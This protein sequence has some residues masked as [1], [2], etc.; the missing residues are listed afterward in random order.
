MRRRS[1]L[2]ALSG[3][4][5]LVAIGA[6]AG[7]G[8]QQ[9]TAAS[10]TGTLRVQLTDDPAAYDAVNLQIV[11]VAVHRGDETTAPD[12]SASDTSATGTDSSGWEVLSRDAATYDLLSLRNGVLATLAAAPIPAGHYTQVRLKLGAGSNV[13]VNGET[14]DLKVPSGMQS[15][16]KLIGN[17][18]VPAGGAV[19]VAVDFDASRSVIHNGAGAY[20]LKPTARVVVMPVATTGSIQGAVSPSD[21]AVSA[22]AISNGDTVAS[23]AT[24]AGDSAFVIPML[25]PGSYDVALH[26]SATYADT[27]ITGVGV[28]AGNV[29]DIGTVTLT[30]Q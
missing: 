7:C 22:F 5:V 29:T 2:P 19:D 24:A 1:F 23:A 21:V 8:R 4:I 13:V 12:T 10:G 17:F 14:H 9:P 28:T 20:L 16:Y 25:P 27:T 3:L 6:L 15:G 18:D 11:E 30:P 26:P